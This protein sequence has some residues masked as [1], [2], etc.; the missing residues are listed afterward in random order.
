MKPHSFVMQAEQGQ[1]RADTSLA[2]AK[3]THIP[4][5]GGQQVGALDGLSG[6]SPRGKADYGLLV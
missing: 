5:S 4:E 6:C 2:A 3:I 1:G